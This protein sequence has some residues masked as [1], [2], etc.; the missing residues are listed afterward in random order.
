MKRSIKDRYGE[1]YPLR[2]VRHPDDTIHLELTYRE[3]YVGLVKWTLHPSDIMEVHD[4]HI[5]D[6]SE[7]TVPGDSIMER[8]MK[9]ASSRRE[10]KNYRHRGLGTVLLKLL[11]VM[12]RENQVKQVRGSIIEKDTMRTPN[13]IEWYEKRGFRKGPPYPGCVRKAIAWIYLNLE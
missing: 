9:Q 5:R 13:L 7:P 1:T 3:D 2:A 6:D 12:A 11:L 8:L 10:I 4:L